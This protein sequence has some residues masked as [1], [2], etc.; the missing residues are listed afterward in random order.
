MDVAIR[1][2]MVAAAAGGRPEMFFQTLR[3]VH[4]MAVEIEM[5]VADGSTPHLRRED[6]RPYSLLDTG[7]IS[8]L[9]E[10]LDREGVRASALLMMTDFSSD[11]ADYHVVMSIRACAAARELGVPV[12]R[13]DPLTKNKA[14]A[15]E[16]VRENFVAR[17]RQVLD[18]SRDTGVDLGVENHG[19][20][21]CDPRWLDAVL[22]AVPDPR[23]GL[24]LDTGNFYWFGFPVSEMYGLIERF[25]PRAKHTHLKNINFPKELADVKREVGHGY[26]EYCCPLDEGNLDLKRVVEILRTAGGYARDLCVEDESLFKYGPDDK[27]NVLRRD[28]AAV[29][30]AM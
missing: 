29:R 15:P 27:V 19:P 16:Q 10:R 2:A 11:D 21:A 12:V 25:A 8:A 20:V 22:D 18:G 24:T 9:R 26:K 3:L 17:V 1:D 14:L 5:A 6:G 30:A 28:V 23:L 13:I 4:C 7:G